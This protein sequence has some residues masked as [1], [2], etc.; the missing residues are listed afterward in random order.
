GFAVAKA[1]R[2]QAGLE[3][4]NIVFLTARGTTDDKMQGYDAGA[5]IYVVKPFDNDD[6][7]QRVEDLLTINF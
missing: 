5:E 7:L 6:L 3:K 2:Q 1:I 4:T